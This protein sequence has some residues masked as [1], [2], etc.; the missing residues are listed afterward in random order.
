MAD[1]K[2]NVEKPRPTRI[3]LDEPYAL[4]DW[5]DKFGVTQQQVREAVEKVGP[6]ANDVQRELQ[7]SSMRSG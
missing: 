5:A 2:S 7:Q 1:Q 6:V 3:S 4:Q